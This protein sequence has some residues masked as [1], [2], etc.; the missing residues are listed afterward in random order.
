MTNVKA[1]PTII[2]NQNIIP[3]ISQLIPPYIKYA[4]WMLLAFVFVFVFILVVAGRKWWIRFALNYKWPSRVSFTI[5]VFSISYI[6]WM[7]MALFSWLLPAWIS[8][9]SPNLTATAIKIG[10]YGLYIGHEV[11]QLIPNQKGIM[12]CISVMSK[13][14][15]QNQNQTCGNDLAC[16]E[17]MRTLSR[18]DILARIKES[19]ATN[20]DQVST[21]CKDI[22]VT[23][24]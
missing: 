21:A 1:D 6:L 22:D 2:N 13:R 4:N 7:G 5:L 15:I 19:Q 16:I 3:D 18:E 24:L 10:I 20:I 23:K 9:E 12:T 11:D 8:V 14:E 17:R